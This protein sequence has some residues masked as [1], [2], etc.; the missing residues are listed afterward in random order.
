MFTT[1]TKT[2]SSTWFNKVEAKIDK[3]EE[4]VLVNKVE[5]ETQKDKDNGE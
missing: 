2:F 3:E 5:A 4:F 1:F